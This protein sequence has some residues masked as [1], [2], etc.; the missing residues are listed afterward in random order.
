[1]KF[2]P[3]LI[4]TTYL[5]PIATLGAQTATELAPITIFGEQSTSPSFNNEPASNNELYQ[6]EFIE[7]GITGV[8]GISR[9]IANFHI[10]D[11]GLGSY[12]RV[13]SMRGLTNTDVFSE[14]A[15]VVYVDDVPYSSAMATMG[16]LFNIDSAT[17]YRSS[18]PGRFGKN[19]Y[20]G[21]VDIK[22]RQPEDRLNS[23]VALELGNFNQHQV[24]VNSS[25]ALLKNRLYFSVG[26][27]YQQR[28]AF[29]YNSYLN[30]SPDEQE[31]F[32]GRATL[33]WTPDQAWDIRLTLTKEDFDYGANR[34]V[35]LDSPDFF[36]VRSELDEKLEQRSDSQALRVAYEHGDYEL[37]AV[38]SHRFWD[39][40]PRLVDLNLTPSVFT[41]SQSTAEE[42]WTQEL[43]L[44]PKDRRGDWDW[45]AGLFYSTLGKHGVLDTFFLNTRTHVG[46][47]QREVDD[48]AAFG[49]LAYQGINR[50]K[51][52]LDLRIDHVEASVD[53]SNTFPNGSTIA[54]QQHDHDFFAS[55]K[56]GMDIRLS[57]HSLVYAAS[58][59]S[60]KPSGFT[61]ANINDNLSHYDK[62]TVWHNELGIKNQWLDQRFQLNLAGF[63]YAID[64]YQVERFFTQ[65]DY[66]M[67]NAPKAHSYGFEVESQAQLLENLALETKLGQTNTYFDD[68][69]D[70]ITRVD[71]AGKAA[72]FIPD[73]TSLIALQYKHPQGYFARTE[74]LVTGRI[75]FDEN[76][77]ELMQQNNYDIANLRIGYVQK[78]YSLYVFANNLADNRYYTTKVSGIRGTPG[79][80]RTVGVRLAVSF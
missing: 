76:N 7:R 62:E 17:V 70:P 75:Y 57:D 38:S 40:G 74:W 31:H 15:V 16:H 18:E 28:D 3:L 22:T 41:R 54:L 39:M 19:A 12:A 59:W 1:M 79:D 69:R 4:L 58:G 72:P 78:N 27:E 32:S 24:T 61:I 21:A 11:S 33:K 36:T 71:Y 5:L 44:R 26:G 43:R 47:K 8:D 66:G 37:L 23:S 63:Y 42:A 67:V 49:Q 13:F 65:F 29:L 60:F 52:Y 56:L 25:G 20:A 46:L 68:Y 35:R 64:N 14:P 50:V 9:Q 53:G 51:I 2:K 6:Q 10:T 45:H 55:P 77:T 73:L 34:F 30:T 80:P 48:Y